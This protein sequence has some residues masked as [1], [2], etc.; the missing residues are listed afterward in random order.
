MKVMKGRRYDK[1]D[2]KVTYID[3]EVFNNELKPKDN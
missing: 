3:S 1:R 2:I